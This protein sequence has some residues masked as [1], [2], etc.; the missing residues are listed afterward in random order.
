MAPCGWTVTSCGCGSSWDTHAPAAQARA[1]AMAAYIMWSATG[2]RYG[3]CEITVMPAG[4]C[5]GT[6]GP[7]EGYRVYPLGGAG[8]GLLSPVIDGGQWYNRPGGGCCSTGCEVL[9]DG[10]TTTAG[11]VSVTVAGVLVDSDA[12]VV[13]DGHL[14]VR[15]DGGCWPCCSNWSSPSTAFTV[16]YE[17]GL[18]IPAAVQAAF[19]ALAC[20]LAKA[21]AGATCALPRT[22]T[23]LTRQG[24]DVEMAE[25]P[26]DADGLI[27]T[28]IPTVDQ[29]I[30]ADN[31]SRLSAPPL[32]LSPDVPRSRRVT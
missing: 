7:D 24:V 1:Q 11:I 25:F 13:Q 15:I 8:G 20:E 17:I 26:T 31:P 10:P 29:V 14:L 30:R 19:E 5:A 21:C 3:P 28:G 12:Y 27:L 4:M 16:V 23:R 6:P 22:V 2:R 9:L 32:V 18:A